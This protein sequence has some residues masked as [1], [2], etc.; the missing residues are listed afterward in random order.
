MIEYSR[1]T[2]RHDN[3]PEQRNVETFDLFC[4]A[5][6]ADRA[7]EKGHQYICGPMAI[8]PDDA[9]HQSQKGFRGSI[10]MPHRCKACARPR[11]WIGLDI[12]GGMT[13]ASYLQMGKA[14]AGLNALVYTTASHTEQDFHL[15]VI[16][17]LDRPLGRHGLQLAARALRNHID[18]AAVG[19]NINWDKQ[20]DNSEQPLFLPLVGAPHQRLVG[21]PLDV[22]AF[23]VQEIK[24]EK[25]EAYELG[26]P[27]K[28]DAEALGVLQAELGKLAV[29]EQGGR[30][31]ALNKTAHLLGGFVGAHRLDQGLVEGALVHATSAWSNPQ[32]TLGTIRSA[33]ASGM[34]KPLVQRAAVP[35]MVGAHEALLG[36]G[37][38]SPCS[39]LANAHRIVS[40]FAGQLLYVEEVG[41]HINTGP[42]KLD[43]L[44]ASK[45]VYGLSK[46]VAKE[47]EAL[48]LWCDQARSTAERGERLAV[49]EAREKWARKCEQRAVIESA[50]KMAQP[51][52]CCKASD[53]DAD[54]MLLGMKNGV[55]DL[56]TCTVRPFSPADR[57]S[58]STLCDYD[59]KAVSPSFIKLIHDITGGDVQL[60]DYLQRILGYALSGQRHEQ[61]LPVL[62]GTGANGK[63]TLVT[64]IQEVMGDYAA[65]AAPGLLIAKVAGHDSAGEADLMGRRLVV[66]S[67]TGESERLNEEQVKR[68]TS[69]E[70]IKARRLYQQY[71]QFNPT[72]LILLQT[73]H[74][75]RVAGTDHGIWRRLKLIPFSVTI[76]E[77]NRDATLGSKLRSEYAGVLKWMVEGWKKYQ[78]EGLITPP[79]VLQATAD[80][81]SASDQVGLFI[82]EMCEV[83]PQHRCTSG[84]LYSAYS[85]WASE[86]GERPMSQRR[87]TQQL[88]ERS[89]FQQTR[90]SSARG[91]SGI[92]LLVIRPVA[93]VPPI[94]GKLQIP[95]LVAPPKPLTPVTQ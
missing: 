73:N 15:R 38:L 70:P 11:R 33:L 28:S 63:S 20:C 10:G 35:Q 80:Y 8:A 23:N 53:M 36:S 89:Q 56:T 34:H 93:L 5:I 84:Q 79:S 68:L 13:S 29:V 71:V 4:E 2:H 62:Y 26:L 77:A 25:S 87:F 95:N 22:Q 14:L 54:P 9:L 55:L 72:H 49:V 41:W 44:A 61:M 18:E 47:V 76:P 67:E 81:R 12:D 27:V 92:R 19:C 51:L 3:K 64:A 58:R 30:N 83:G 1:G 52:M 37:S 48:K 43:E 17:E 66:V 31:N 50:M 24:D 21:V 88:I 91:W 60:A 74:K 86:M 6:L 69:R 65:T 46:I 85:T 39:D 94:V 32:K 7:V 82:D 45:T 75:P 16:V 90:S 40:H 42:W 57:I 78:R 59:A